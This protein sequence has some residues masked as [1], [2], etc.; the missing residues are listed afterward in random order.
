M[1][2]LSRRNSTRLAIVVGVA[3][4]VAAIVVLSFVLRDGEV[5]APTDGI[6]DIPTA[7]LVPED[8]AL[9][10][11]LNTDIDSDS[12]SDAFALLERLGVED[13]LGT[14]REGLDEEAD[15]DWDEEF[16]PFLGGAAVLFLSS[17]N[18]GDD[19][20]RG[21]VIFHARD[22]RGAEAVILDRRNDGFAEREYR[23][24]AY[25]VTEDG[26]VLAVIGDHFVYATDEPSLH[27]IVDAH[28][29]DTRSLADS[30]NFRR[31]RNA[32]E[33]DAL[34]FFYVHPGNLMAEVMED[35]PE[36]GEPGEGGPDI[37]SM[38]GLGDLFAEPIGVVVRAGEGSFS[39]QAIML[40]E[41]GPIARLL[42]PRESRFASLVPAETAVFVSTFDVAG[43]VD[44][45]FGSSGFGELLRNAVDESDGEV[46]EIARI[47]EVL[48]L[49][50]GEVALAMW[51]V[52]GADRTEAVFLA[53]VDDEDRARELLEELLGESL[54]EGETVLFVED[55]I[56]MIGTSAAI[57][58]V[59]DGGG[60]SL[61]D[62]K[63]YSGAVAQ[64]DAPLATFAYLDIWRFIAST[65]EEF[66]NLDLDGDSLGVI[67]NLVWE[68]DRVQVEAALTVGA[69]D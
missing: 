64:L 41:P 9:Y 44:D 30:D 60:P 59:R 49:L 33:G 38:L 57:A 36:T 32:L 40:G 69:T 43:V 48:S 45:F 42:R 68:D 61:A 17:F 4:A 28:R 21:A 2:I 14:V 50:D 27:D 1:S 55:G 35:F 5:P 34:A 62:S 66:D 47:E 11:A 58:T 56:A 8:V 7:H 3:L 53:E 46:G 25:K 67:V 10:V 24:I 65:A 39:L 20:P 29:G 26:G 18:S 63:R 16:E 22:A 19:G 15:V 37:L 54:A 6:G 12:W 52:D 23:D 13:P 51:P 31:L